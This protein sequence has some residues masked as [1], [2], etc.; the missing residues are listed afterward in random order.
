MFRETDPVLF[1]FEK[2]YLK[3]NQSNF[4]NLEYR[5]KF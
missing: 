1:Y 2:N 5:T 4:G 3:K